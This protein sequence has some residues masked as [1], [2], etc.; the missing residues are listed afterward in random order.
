[1]PIKNLT[2]GLCLLLAGRALAQNQTHI[3]HSGDTVS[4]L[5]SHYHT[6]WNAIAHASGLSNK[7]RLKLGQKLVIPVTFDRKATASVPKS[8]NYTVREGDSDWTIS[9]RAGIEASKLHKLNP[10]VHWTALQVGS[11]LLVPGV[12]AEK[13]KVAVAPLRSKFALVAKD[14]V[15][16]RDAPSR[17]ADMIVT[18]DQGTRVSVIARDG[19]WY[20]LRFPKGTEGWVRGDMLQAAAMKIAKH[21]RSTIHV[22]MSHATPSSSDNGYR[23]ASD[24]SQQKVID[25]AKKYRGVRYVWGSASRSG[26]DCSGFAL[27]VYRSQ[28]IRL[29][30]TS[31][32]QATVGRAVHGQLQ[33]GDLVFFKT[34]RTSRISH[35]GIYVGN[36]KFIHASSGGGHVQVNSLREGYYRNRFATARRFVKGAT[37]K[38]KAEKV[39]EQPTNDPVAVVAPMATE[40]APP[41]K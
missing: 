30:R 36:G 35:V 19:D 2:L 18:V 23:L 10:S 20:H 24:T 4:A 9:H 6:T 39:A 16:V 3:V 31:T 26:T 28:G 22:A 15:V 25:T 13:A 38:P 1:M 5:A 11:R 33:A 17:A 12:H 21:R 41:S 8:G 37:A 32:Q 7:E 34:T 40:T 14:S 27:Q 29:P